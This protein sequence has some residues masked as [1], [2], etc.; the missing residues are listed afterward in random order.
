MGGTFTISNLGMFGIKQ[1]TAVINPPQVCIMAVG[2]NQQKYVAVD[3]DLDVFISYLILFFIGVAAMF[4]G[5]VNSIYLK[6]KSH[7]RY[8]GTF[9]SIR[10]A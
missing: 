1:F 10:S 4:I 6:Q 9:S 2:G 3:G 8:H 7:F 5:F